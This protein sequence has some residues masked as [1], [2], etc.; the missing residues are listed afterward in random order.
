MAAIY[1]VNFT[2]GTFPIEFTC[3]DSSHAD[4][5]WYDA[6]AE[7]KMPACGMRMP[8]AAHAAYAHDAVSNIMINDQVASASP[9]KC[10]V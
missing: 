3:V 1:S 4:R 6:Y 10:D 2:E 8:A 5:W 9:L 7:T